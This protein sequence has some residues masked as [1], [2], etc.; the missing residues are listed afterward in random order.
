MLFKKLAM[1]SMTTLYAPTPPP[2]E[3]CA[4]RLLVG[5]HLP[6]KK[7]KCVK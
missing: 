4:V 5:L 3:T 7:K 2:L 6:A 1:Q